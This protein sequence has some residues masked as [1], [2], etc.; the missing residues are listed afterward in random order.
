MS[1]NLDNLPVPANVTQANTL[2][3]I[4]NLRLEGRQQR[5]YYMER[6]ANRIA[7]LEERLQ[8][9]MGYIDAIPKDTV[10]PAMPGFDRDWMDSIWDNREVNCEL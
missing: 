5:A 7:E 1:A 6:M 9:A 10:L 4:R 8:A 2:V 3:I